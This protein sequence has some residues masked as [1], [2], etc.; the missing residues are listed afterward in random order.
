[1][2]KI[3][4]KNSKLNPKKFEDKTELHNSSTKNIFYLNKVS[5]IGSFLKKDND[6]M[7]YNAN[8]RNFNYLNSD[9]KLLV[10]VFFAFFL[11]NLHNIR[12]AL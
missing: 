9:E 2:S 11:I 8:E 12:K 6:V 7:L 1:M 5:F 4:K 3:I 10:V